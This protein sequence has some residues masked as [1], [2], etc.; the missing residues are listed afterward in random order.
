MTLHMHNVYVFPAIH[1][2]CPLEDGAD[3][4][5]LC[6]DGILV[7][8]LKVLVARSHSFATAASS[9]MRKWISWQQPCARW[10]E[11]YGGSISLFRWALNKR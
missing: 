1:L 9:Q 5:F 6:S 10:H 11:C 3:W 8:A 4:L 7:L 2:F